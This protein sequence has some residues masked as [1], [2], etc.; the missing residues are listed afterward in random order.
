[1]ARRRNRS[2][3]PL[4]EFVAA[5][6][7]LMA[8]VIFLA[9]ESL[10]AAIVTF[11]LIVGLAIA[12]RLYLN[13]RYDQKLMRSGIHDIDK[14]DGRQFELYLGL[15]FKALGYKTEVTRFMGDFGADLVIEKDG[16][17]TVVQ[18]KC[19]SKNVGIEAVQQIYAAKAHYGATNAMVITN[20]GFTEAAEELAKSNGVILIGREK[21]ID[22]MLTMNPAQKPDTGVVMTENEMTDK[23]CPR[24]GNKLVL[25]KGPKGEFLGCSSFPKCRFTMKTSSKIDASFS[26]RVQ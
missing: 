10:P 11:G 7:V 15:L 18:A 25:R 21:L 8:I 5:V 3:D 12:L 9:T 1:M 22:M 17:R 26:T 13:Y 19:Y 23:T 14:M 4:V 20:R 16:V 6:S 24:C 2:G